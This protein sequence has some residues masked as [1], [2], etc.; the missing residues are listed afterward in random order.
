[1]LANLKS[2]TIAFESPLRFPDRESRR[3]PPPTRTILPSLTRF[4][5]KG[6]SEYL[7]HL[8]ARID[9]PLLDSISISFFHRLIFGIP[10]LA[11]FMRRTTK[12]QTLDE[13]H[14]DFGCSSVRVGYLPPRRIFDEE[15]GLRISY[16]S[17]D[18]QRFSL[19]QV[20]TS[21][22]PSISMVEHLYIYGPPPQWQGGVVNMQW[23]EFF[24]LFTGVRNLYVCEEYVQS[25][26]NVL[27]GLVRGRVAGVLPA[28]ESLFL[29]DLQSV[30]KAIG[31]F[32]A[33]RRLSGH[34]VAV[35]PWI[36]VLLQLIPL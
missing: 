17:L 1:V 12:F 20:F 21:F 6:V 35:S 5:F 11:Q 2:L 23:L 19:A 36:R 30:E 26:A 16:R 25:I 32:V 31:Q 8:V 3:P 24:H 27:K 4:R 10:Q 7:E 18:R 9:T 33:A 15:S 28:L 34:P 22:F 14:V 13:A 29:E